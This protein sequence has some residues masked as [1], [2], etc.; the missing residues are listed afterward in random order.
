MTR[1][2]SDDLCARV[3][4]VVVGEQTCRAAALLRSLHSLLKIAR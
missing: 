3:A 4:A 1:T 2:Y